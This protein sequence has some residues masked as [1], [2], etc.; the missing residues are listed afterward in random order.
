MARRHLEFSMAPSGILINPVAQPEIWNYS[1]FPSTWTSLL[2]YPI[3]HLLYLLNSSLL[4][5]P[6]ATTVAEVMGISWRMAGPVSLVGLLLPP[7]ALSP[8]LH[9]VPRM[10]LL[11]YKSN[12]ISPSRV[13]NLCVHSWSPPVMAPSFLRPLSVWGWGD[14]QSWHL[15]P[16]TTPHWVC[17]PCWASHALLPGNFHLEWRCL[18]AEFIDMGGSFMG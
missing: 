7:S 2:F 8:I 6:P 3:N 10:V 9:Q 15:G 13:G 18:D 11:E 12:L 14:W 4:H 16:R 5:A 17:V 1:W